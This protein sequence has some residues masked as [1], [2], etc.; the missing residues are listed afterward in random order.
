MKC[1]QVVEAVVVQVVGRL[2]EQHHVMPAEHQGGE[3]EPGLLA[4]GQP[5]SWL[6]QTDRQSQPGQH[7]FGADVE[8]GTSEGRPALQRRRIATV[9][10]R[11]ALGKAVGSR[12]QGV[13]S[14]LDAGAPAEEPAGCLRRL[15]AGGLGPEPDGGCVGAGPNGPPVDGVLSGDGPE[16]G[17]LARAIGADHGHDLA[18]TH[19]QVEVGD[20]L[21]GA[22]AQRDP[23]KSQRRHVTDRKAPVNR[24]PPRE[25]SRVRAR[26]TLVP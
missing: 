21:D 5:G 13:C 20:K 3:G 11:P 23:L 12:L 10:T 15:D 26:P 25:F 18:G 9:G 7:P 16:E 8:V 22:V 6:V 14:R 2:V 1:L 24:D 17:R 4:T 19:G